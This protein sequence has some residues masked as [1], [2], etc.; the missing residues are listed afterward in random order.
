MRWGIRCAARAH[1][2]SDVLLTKLR[3]CARR[4]RTRRRMECESRVRRTTA[5][6]PVRWSACVWTISRTCALA[7]H[8]VRSPSERSAARVPM[9]L[10]WSWASCSCAFVARIQPM[11]TALRAATMRGQSPGPWSASVWMGTPLAVMGSAWCARP[12]PCST[13]IAACCAAP[14]STA[15]AR[16]T[17]SHAPA[18]CTRTAG[19][20]CARRVG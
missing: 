10:E 12:G 7:A 19:R 11:G 8:L 16:R 15:W 18:I 17:T 2:D 3:P 14:G 4:E 5:A 20:G 6:T 1:W 13:T 9:G